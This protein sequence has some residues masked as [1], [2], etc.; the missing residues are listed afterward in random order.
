MMS[1]TLGDNSREQQHVE[2]LHGEESADAW[3]EELNETLML[4]SKIQDWATLQTQIKA[5]L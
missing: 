2:D 4:N 1:N 5:D 3:E